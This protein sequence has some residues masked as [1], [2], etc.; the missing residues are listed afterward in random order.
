[1]KKGAN[2]DEDS[3]DDADKEVL[4]QMEKDMEQYDESV[5]DVEPE[6]KLRP[7]IG[8]LE[9]DDHILVKFTGTF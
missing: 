4:E 3:S 2:S 6:E 1:M 8:E 5:S 7:D 9:I